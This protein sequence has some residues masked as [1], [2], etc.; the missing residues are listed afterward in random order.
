MPLKVVNFD[1]WSW[2]GFLKILYLIFRTILLSIKGH[3][4]RKWINLNS[5]FPKSINT[6]TLVFWNSIHAYGLQ[7]S[8]CQP[9]LW[10]V[11]WRAPDQIPTAESWLVRRWRGLLFSH[12]I[13]VWWQHMEV[14]A[15]VRAFGLG[16]NSYFLFVSSCSAAS[17]FFISIQCCLLGWQPDYCVF[18]VGCSWMH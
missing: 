3:S 8:R 18:V 7:Q 2:K 12:I 1:I 15:V 13:G 5:P 4:P 10:H 11:G 9:N 14:C 17:A 6:W 16:K